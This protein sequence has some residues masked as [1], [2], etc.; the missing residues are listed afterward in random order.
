MKS[1]FSFVEGTSRESKRLFEIHQHGFRLNL[2]RGADL[3]INF[4][5]AVDLV[6]LSRLD[7]LTAEVSTSQHGV[8]HLIVKIGA[9]VIKIRPETMEESQRIARST[10]V[11]FWKSHRMGDI[12]T[13]IRIALTEENI[14]DNVIQ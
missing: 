6:H 13:T 4:R 7:N 14:P 12:G 11:L 3:Q 5:Y 1:D 9:F 2:H 10:P 8:S